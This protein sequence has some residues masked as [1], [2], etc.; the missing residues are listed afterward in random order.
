MTA[1]TTI[2]IV[3]PSKRVVVNRIER[4]V[5]VRPQVRR[6]QVINAQPVVEVRPVRRTVELAA[7]GLRGE[8]GP[9]GLPGGTYYEHTQSPAAAT[10]TINHNLGFR[11]T[12]ELRTAGGQEFIADVQHPTV[13]Q[14]VVYLN[15]PLAGFA[16]LI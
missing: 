11:P 16:R 8:R 14:V 12:V 5:E 9:M 13:N 3:A 15:S 6:V 1:C 2:N 7:R 10:W 4:V